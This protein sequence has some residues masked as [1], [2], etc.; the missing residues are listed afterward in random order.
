MQTASASAHSIVRNGRDSWRTVSNKY[1]FLQENVERKYCQ[2]KNRFQLTQ[3]DKI[4]SH[5]IYTY[6]G[7]DILMTIP[8]PRNCSSSVLLCQS[9][10]L[11]PLRG[12]PSLAPILTLTYKIQ[13]FSSS[14]FI[15]STMIMIKHA[16]S[17]YR[18]VILLLSEFW[19]CYMTPFSY[20]FI[21]VLNYTK[22]HSQ[23]LKR[24]TFLGNTFQK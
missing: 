11:I 1:L 19:H 18:K 6:Q 15:Y 5:H 10:G 24:N 13:C 7:W 20:L 2:R 17:I 14:L 16:A 9:L 23:P 4:Q 12:F 22:L 21:Y 8:P 3:G